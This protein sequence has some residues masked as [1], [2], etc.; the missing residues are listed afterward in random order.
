MKKTL[1][2]LVLLLTGCGLNLSL[3]SEEEQV[4]KAI[5][6]YIEKYYENNIEVMIPVEFMMTEIDFYNSLDEQNFRTAIKRQ[7][8]NLTYE[9]QRIA[10]F[11]NTAVV[12][13][14]IYGYDFL[15]TYKAAEKYA[16]E[17]EITFYNTSGDLYDNTFNSY[18][19]KKMMTETDR[20]K[21]DITINVNYKNEKWQVLDI[22][23][24]YLEKI[25]GLYEVEY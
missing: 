22:S 6:S 16:L 4:E 13:M 24:E 17:E 19:F 10:I 2:L 25:Q 21:Y 23:D 8:K 11:N 1:I 18:V 7:Y 9:V 5:D 20:L 3:K 12:N 15:A 14:E